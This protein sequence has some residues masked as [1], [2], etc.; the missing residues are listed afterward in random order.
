MHYKFKLSSLNQFKP[1]RGIIVFFITMMLA[2]WFWKIFVHDGDYDPDVTFLQLDITHPF[3]L[4]QHEVVRV[5]GLL[6]ELFQISFALHKGNIF[7]FAN[8]QNMEVVWGCTGLKQAFIF[9]C[10]ILVS[11]GPWKH[12]CW[13]VPAGWL[14][15]HIVNVS[16]ICF[17]GIVISHNPGSFG[18]MHDYFLKYFF[19]LIIFVVWIMWEEYF[20]KKEL[21]EKMEAED[22]TSVE[23]PAS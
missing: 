6:F 3:L 21:K 17:V 22:S 18:I 9:T 4:L 12:K 23:N 19:Y 15:I 20:F 2:N 8:G 1:L 13:Y 11:R 14:L 5:V 16:R 10:I 7:E